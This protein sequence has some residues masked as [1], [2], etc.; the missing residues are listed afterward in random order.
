MGE[1][2]RQKGRLAR[3]A[4]RVGTVAG[5]AAALLA[6]NAA[7]GQGGDG[8]PLPAA[9]PEPIAGVA[10]PVEASESQ[11]PPPLVLRPSRLGARL[12]LTGH[13]SHRSHSSHSSHVSGSS[14]YSR[15]S[16]HTSHVSGAS[17]FSTH[18]SHSSHYSS[19]TRSFGSGSS[20][21]ST[22]PSIA[23][24]APAF[25][26]PARPVGP[27]ADGDAMNPAPAMDPG[28]AA[29]DVAAPAPAE[30]AR[31]AIDL[32]DPKNRFQLITVSRVNG[33]QKAFI[34]DL[35]RDYR[36]LMRVGETIGDCKLTSIS[37][38]G[39][40][41]RMKPPKGDYFTVERTY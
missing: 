21:T 23:P 7:A 6:E 19:S 8:T 40:W 36:K 37:K 2:G 13:R 5:A 31:P 4:L 38:D 14:S 20:S 35:L 30:A 10:R 26:P 11:T 18:Q 16:S 22:A 17:N 41:V 32:N 39:Q 34:K 12:I 1:D 33:V 28:P 25:R 27:P 3:L 24:S 15:H 29:A 9:R